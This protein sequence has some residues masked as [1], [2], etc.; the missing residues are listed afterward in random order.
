MPSVGSVGPGK[1]VG[2]KGEPQLQHPSNEY[3]G[4]ISVRID[5]FALKSLLQHHSYS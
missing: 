1:E 3:S 5:W 2:K 4:L